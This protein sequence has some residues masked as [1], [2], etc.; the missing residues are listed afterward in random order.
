[1]TPPKDR[2]FGADRVGVRME[3]RVPT[4][5]T[6][7]SGRS[8]TRIQ[9]GNI[10]SRPDHDINNLILAQWSGR[11][12]LAGVKEIMLFILRASEDDIAKMRGEKKVPA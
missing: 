11:K 7:S 8:G 5:S 1:M 10:S 6:G 3:F 9:E 2:M 4:G 12:E